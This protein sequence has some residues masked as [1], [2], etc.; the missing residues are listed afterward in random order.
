M[1]EFNSLTRRWTV[2]VLGA[3]ALALTACGGPKQ[4]TL[5]IYNWSG[6]M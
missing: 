5:H 3:A 2:A 1:S 4:D 6:S